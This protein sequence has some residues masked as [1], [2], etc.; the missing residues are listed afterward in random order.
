MIAI[1]PL[2]VLL[3]LSLIL[4]ACSP[5]APAPA[6]TAEAP[7]PSAPTAAATPASQPTAAP[8]A[9]ATPA[10]GGAQPL[11]LSIIWHQHQPV[12]YKDP[13]TGVYAKPWVRLH[14]AKDY[15][16]MAQMLQKYPNVHVTFNLTPSLLR[17][18]RDIEAGA[19]DAYWVVAAKDAAQL[20][21]DDKRFLLRHFF[22]ANPKI[23]QR[24]PRYLELQGKR[25]DTGSD[26][27]IDATAATWSEADFRDLQVLFNLGWTDPD[28]LEEPALKAL[29]DKRA[30]YTEADKQVVLNRHL[31]LVKR[32]IPLHKQMQDAGQI[33]VTMT[34]Y[35]HPILPLLITTDEAKQAMPDAKLPSPAFVYGQDAQAQIERGVALYQELF[36][37]PPRGMWPGEG[38]VSQLI[39]GPVA[40]AGIKWMAS[41]EEVLAKSIGLNQFERD[42]QDTVQQPD[43]L[44]QPYLTTDDRGQQVAMVFRDRTISDKLGFTYSGQSG[45]AASSDVI[46]RLHDIQA[47][48]KGAAG[49]HLVT[50]ILDGENAWENYDND[51]KAF[52]NSLYQKLSDDSAIKTVT[53]SEYLAQFPA[54]ARIDKLWAGSWINADFSTWIGEPEENKAWGLLRDARA[55][56]QKY[57]SGVRKAEPAAIAKAQDLMYIAEGSDWF[58]WYGADQDS[59]DDGAF[60]RQFRD[61]LREIYTTLGADVPLAVDVPIIAAGS[62]EPDAAP[63]GLLA[64]TLDGQLAA[65]EWDAAGRF[66]V[67]GGVAQSGDDVVGALRYGFDAK[68]LYVAVEPR[69]SW[70]ALGADGT[71]GV[72]LSA[73][74]AGATSPVSRFGAGQQRTLLGFDAGAVAEVRLAGG[75]LAGEATLSDATKDGWAPEP[76]AP[77]KA[78]VGA[79]A[80][81]L[82]IPLELLGQFETGDAITLR[83]VVSR[84]G[85]DIQTLPAAS[86]ASL[87]VPDL[88]LSTAILDVKDAEGDDHGPGSYTYPQDAVFSGGVFDL[89][90]FSVAEDANN[91]IF[92]LV[93]KGGIDNVWNSPRGMSVQTFDIYIGTNDASSAARLLFPGRNA[94]I[95]QGQGWNYGLW[96]EGWEGG[97]FKAKPAGQPDKVGGV[98][99]KTIVDRKAGRVTVRL[100]KS[101][102]PPGDPKTW[103]YQAAVLGQE[104]FPAAG[105]WRVRDVTSA[106]Q[107]W[108]FGGA[109][110][111]TNGTRIIDLALP[112]GAPTTQEQALKPA[113]ASDEQN[114]DKLGPD[115]FAQVPMLSVK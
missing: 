5:G 48:L 36:G 63:S 102:L 52:L 89:T 67:S 94:A 16:D 27:A 91:L 68:N 41:D 93:V 29:V 56:L 25:G 10:E 4:S 112:E 109:L 107:Q 92:K 65:G 30:G 84:A 2:A 62:T 82:A 80:V 47:A 13:A 28:W 3:A 77:L 73:Q 54:Q 12:Y 113:K 31:E 42:G 17:Q 57:L 108:R 58:W 71:I 19:R 104:G 20:T 115:D 111:G 21:A 44:Y 33:E 32:V 61:T 1:R 95:R 86:Q 97:L 81:E 14:A 8:T 76:R 9:A 38:S 59:G 60:D 55:T 6:P 69:G 96:I 70:G 114:L 50:I 78:A 75:K 106:A 87:S 26:A 46:K 39:V 101:A 15:V 49:P 105:V 99:I 79:K 88:G 23:I 74:S 34:P 37:R 7:A 18:I 53:P 85:K 35:A 103:T 72:Y 98:E 83:A 90:E 110:P 43:K 11:Y 45:D 100:P 24:F 64:P 66:G 22:D 40:G 51:G